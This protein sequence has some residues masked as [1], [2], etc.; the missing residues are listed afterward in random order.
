MED[1]PDDILLSLIDKLTISSI[2][3]LFCSSRHF[4]QFYYNYNNYI[5]KKSCLKI[6]KSP[7][8]L[9]YT[10]DQYRDLFN[11]YQRGK[12]VRVLIDDV[13]LKRMKIYP[14]DSNNS[15]LKK[16]SANTIYFL[17]RSSHG[18]IFL[19]MSSNTER[20]IL[21]QYHNNDAELEFYDQVGQ[22]NII[23]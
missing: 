12:M 10:P 5:H 11:K 13:Y 20:N 9:T 6:N 1:L 3:N 16:L 23:T 19:G 22:L 17:A 21:P 2:V 8:L 4:L 18:D 14:S 15:L 7:K